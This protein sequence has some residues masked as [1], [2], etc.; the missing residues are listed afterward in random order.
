MIVAIE[1]A[2]GGGKGFF[3]K[4]LTT[5]LR[6][7]GVT[8]FSTVLLDDSISNMMD[9]SKDQKRW[10][11]FNQF[12]F[13]MKH[14]KAVDHQSPLT[15]VEGSMG[16]DYQCMARHSMGKRLMEHHEASLVTQWY[17]FLNTKAW[18]P[19]A[20]I[21][22]NSDPQN[23]FERV[24][25][26]SKREQAY[27]SHGTLRSLKLRFD[28]YIGLCPVPVLNLQCVPNFEDNEPVLNKMAEETIRFLKNTFKDKVYLLD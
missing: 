8:S 6:N 15:F 10:A 7:T 26:N 25:N 16:S 22:L 18:R 28:E 24:V 2:P 9:Y 4:H 27:L 19:D 5:Y 23:H 12:D 17:G 20:I 3:L 11:A 14:F 21:Y 13:L 1:S